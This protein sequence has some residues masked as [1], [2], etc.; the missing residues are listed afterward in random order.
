MD[1]RPVAK[2]GMQVDDEL[3]FLGWECAALEVGSQVVNPTKAAAF[4]TPLQAG[5]PSDIAPAPLS[6]SQHVAHEL[7]IFFRRPQALPKLIVVV[8][9]VIV[10]NVVI[11]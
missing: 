7:L 10:S 2:D 4:A 5:I 3:F 8:L 11:D 1:I 9:V 6:I